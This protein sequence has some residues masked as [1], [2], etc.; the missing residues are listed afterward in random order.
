MTKD[1]TVTLEDSTGRTL[2]LNINGDTIDEMI[3]AGV[4]EWRAR[5]DVESN[6]FCNAIYEGLIGED[7]WLSD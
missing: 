5:E 3:A 4:E 6:A 7:A 1:Y 2:A